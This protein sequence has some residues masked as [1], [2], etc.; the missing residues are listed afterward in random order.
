MVVEVGNLS[1]L[2]P[3]PSKQGLQTITI[4]RLWPICSELVGLA[5]VNTMKIS[6]CSMHLSLLIDEKMEAISGE[7]LSL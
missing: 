3:A 4:G 5:L 7:P 2:K 1:P 6:L